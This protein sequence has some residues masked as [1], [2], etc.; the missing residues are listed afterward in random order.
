MED[1]G[2][3]RPREVPVLT[4]GVFDQMSSLVALEFRRLPSGHLRVIADDGPT[5]RALRA[6]EGR[7]S[8]PSTSYEPSGIIYR[9]RLEGEGAQIVTFFGHRYGTDGHASHDW[10]SRP[11]SPHRP[12]SRQCLPPPADP[13]VL[14]VYL[15]HGVLACQGVEGA[16]PGFVYLPY[17]RDSVDRWISSRAF[18]TSRRTDRPRPLIPHPRA[19][20]LTPPALEEENRADE[21][22]DPEEREGD[23]EERGRGVGGTGPSQGQGDGTGRNA[24]D[25]G[26]GAG[27]S[28][29]DGA[30]G[31]GRDGGT[32]WGAH[33]TPPRREAPTG[34]SLSQLATAEL[35][36]WAVDEV[37]RIPPGEIR[38][39]VVDPRY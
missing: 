22:P 20:A 15:R 31:E 17:A 21:G 12:W 13:P 32:A 11:L 4:P 29:P 25:A 2:E 1:D 34:P 23:D 8:P 27:L 5:A 14:L 6:F 7:L 18:M 10:I 26:A 38:V 16:R 28:T 24:G 35:L 19:A 9:F 36:T 30:A 33:H 37:L 39:F 3:D